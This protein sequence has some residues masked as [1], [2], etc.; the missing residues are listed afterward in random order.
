[1]P[2][3][4]SKA[5]ILGFTLFAFL[6]SSPLGAQ[7]ASNLQAREKVAAV[8]TGFA[9]TW[10]AGAYRLPDRVVEELLYSGYSYAE[11]LVALAYM[12]EG[13]SLND[14]LEQRALLGGARW[15][16]VA[17]TLG[18]EV[19][20]L[21]KEVR[22]LLWFGRNDG[23]PPVLHFLPDPAP[24]IGPTLVL[25]PFSPTVPS[26]V[27]A[28]RFHLKRRDV[29]TIRR[30]LKDPL[31]VPDGELLKPAGAGLTAGDWVLAGAISYFK[32]F[33]MDSLLAARLG[34]DL[35]WSEISLAYGIR[36]D[37]LTEGPLSGIYPVLTGY[38][39]NTVLIA[40]RRADHPERLALRYDLERITPGEK[41][42]LLP[43]LYAFYRVHDSEKALLDETSLE[44]AEKGIALALARMASLDLGLILED[45]RDLGEWPAIVTKY[46]I[47]LSGHRALERSMRVHRG[48][49]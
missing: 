24:G 39:P 17:N 12:N 2:F 38:A 44:L 16:E 8:D 42:A 35:N 9:A 33:P 32:P 7:P 5:L 31:G 47:D 19:E 46:A 29:E 40:R 23:Q 49:R 13:L 18:L 28:D 4:N 41:R 25:P 15:A 3:R 1:M 36:P 30:V 45:H 37:V 10:I 26:M 34:E 11:T 27:T 43:L 21:P 22:D 14:V 6:A 20:D 48:S